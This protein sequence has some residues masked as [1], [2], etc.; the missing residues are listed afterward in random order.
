MRD[1]D[2]E[3]NMEKSLL[4]PK[5]SLSSTSTTWDLL[6]GELKKQGYIAAP[7]VAVTLSQYLLQVVS[8]MMVG[9]LGQL[10]LSSTA[11]AISLASV[12]GFSVLLGMASALETLCGQAYGAQQYQRIGTQIYTA[13]FCL[14]LACFPLSFLGIYMGRLL[15]LVGQDPQISHEVGKFIIWLLPA[16]FAY[17]AMQ[18]LIRYFQSQSLIIPM[19]LSSYAALCLHIP[20]CWA[21]VFKSGLGNLGGA[22]AIGISYWLNVTFLAIYM[23]F[24]TAC[25]ESRAPISMELFRGIGEFFHFAIP[26]AVMVCLSTIQT[27]SAIPYGLGAAVSR[28][29]FGYV[30][31]NEGQVVDYVTTMAPLVCLSVIIDSLQGVFSGVAR[32]CGW[33]NIAAFV[34]LGAYYFC[35][36]PTAAILGFW[37]KFRGRGLWIGIQAGAFTQTLLLGIITTFTD[38]EKQA[39]KARKRLSKGRSLE[40]NR[41]VCE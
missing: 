41:I 5:E 27:L 25:A 12:T 39:S 3:K 14:F 15:V 40:E 7:M 20:S 23:K 31:S 22:L 13:I 37:L 21:L 2:T 33:Q 32:G 35:G 30:F 38:W 34:N 26:S 10:A 4:I 17:A 11:M 1:N 29:V 9:H 6:S 36:V 24:S 18:A 19:F 16:L 8:M 28:R